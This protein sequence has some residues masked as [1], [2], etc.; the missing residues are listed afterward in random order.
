MCQK[1]VQISNCKDLQLSNNTK[2]YPRCAECVDYYHINEETD[3]KFCIKNNCSTETPANDAAAKACPNCKKDYQFTTTKTSSTEQ[4]CVAKIEGCKVF[5]YS[6]VCT[7]CEN[8][9]AMISESNVATCVS[10]ASDVQIRKCTTYNK[11]GN[12]LNYVTC[13]ACESGYSQFPSSS[14][15]RYCKQNTCVTFL[16]GI[17]QKCNDDYHLLSNSTTTYPECIIKTQNMHCESLLTRNSCAKCLD[18]HAIF[19]ETDTSNSNL[20]CKTET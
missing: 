13:S 17:C 11:T 12:T 16:A 19:K 6:G 15:A 3:H 7:E 10:V 20:K 1:D 14:D 5:N 8:N 4:R 2:T 9:Y 18:G